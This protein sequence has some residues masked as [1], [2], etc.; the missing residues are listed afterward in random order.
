MKK[1]IAGLI[2]CRGG[3]MRVPNKNIKSFGNSSLLEIKIQQLKH[4]LTD[5]YVNSD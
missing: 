1:D 3:S 2:A 4:F 5:V